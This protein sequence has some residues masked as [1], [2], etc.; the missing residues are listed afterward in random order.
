MTRETPL[1]EGPRNASPNDWLVT[2][3]PKRQKSQGLPGF[4]QVSVLAP[5]LFLFYINDLVEILPEDVIAAL[6]ANDDLI[7][8]SSTT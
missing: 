5:L 7:K 6:F 2:A 1:H 4:L 8:G 3:L